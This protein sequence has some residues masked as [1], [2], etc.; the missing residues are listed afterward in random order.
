MNIFSNVCATKARK[1]KA[2]LLS[3]ISAIKCAHAS[4][5]FG[6]EVNGNEMT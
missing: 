5:E 6:P 1:L 4:L 3:L 2:K